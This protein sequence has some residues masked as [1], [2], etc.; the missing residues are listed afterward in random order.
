MK[1]YDVVVVGAGLAGLQCARLLGRDGLNVLLLD[2]RQSVTATIRT[3]GIFVRRTFED[4]DFLNGLLG[5][6][7]RD[8]TL[9][10]PARRTLHLQSANDEFR[11][12][13]M[14]AVYEGLLD[15]CIRADVVWSPDT[16]Y[17][18]LQRDER[19]LRIFLAGGTRE[20]VRTRYLVG[21]D[22]ARSRVGRDLGLSQNR[23]WL[24]G[25]EEVLDHVPL[26]G[27]PRLECFLEPT[28][29]PG[30]L[31][32]VAN[33]GHQAH[34]GVAGYLAAFDPLRSMARFRASLAGLVDLTRAQVRERRAGLIPVGGVLPRII[35][36][37]GLLLGDA[38]GAVS[39]LTAGGLDPCLRLSRLGARVIAS[40]LRGGDVASLCHFSGEAFR[41]RFR[42]RLWLRRAAS[43]FRSPL[44]LEVL[45]A[46]LRLPG[47]NRLARSIFFGRGSF[48]DAQTDCEPPCR[49]LRVEL[50][51]SG[52]QAS[53]CLNTLADCG[54]PHWPQGI[55]VR[56]CLLRICESLQRS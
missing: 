27:S 47:G 56:R 46:A 15:D 11:I 5:P 16:S 6:P 43:M 40:F 28:L 9:Y 4:F 3:T 1:T 17:A 50:G 34:V 51:Q 31:A 18:G 49:Y 55:V 38:A 37:Q 30:Y 8:V 22:G 14:N 19:G 44:L 13:R 32:W 39:P 35:N 45:C 52:Q 21:A 7:I 24:V 36:G 26:E 23:T 10:S 41:Q 42:T 29:A 54:P 20:M 48:P 2:R 53:A 12:G 25:V 33:D